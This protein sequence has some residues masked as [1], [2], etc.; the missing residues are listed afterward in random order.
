MLAIINRKTKQKTFISVQEVW[1]LIL[2]S[3]IKKI[4]DCAWVKVK[5]EHEKY[6]DRY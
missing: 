1:V 4:K 2:D 5:S 6:F 3:K